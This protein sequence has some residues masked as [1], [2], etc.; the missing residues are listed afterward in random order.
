MVCS[1]QDKRE[2][3]FSLYELLQE[4]LPSNLLS[5]AEKEKSQIS[6][7]IKFPMILMTSLIGFKAIVPTPGR[8]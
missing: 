3:I 4:L 2:A 7:N 6:T 1:F 5:S 8:P